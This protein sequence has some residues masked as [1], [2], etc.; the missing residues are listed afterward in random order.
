MP[1]YGLAV[2]NGVFDFLP[3]YVTPATA[4]PRFKQTRQFHFVGVVRVQLAG[5]AKQPR[6]NA[7]A[8]SRWTGE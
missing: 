2:D 1:G 7:S 5:N 6:V 8:S 4:T 3:A